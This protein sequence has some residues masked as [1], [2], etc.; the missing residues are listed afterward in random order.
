MKVFYDNFQG[1]S[2]EERLCLKTC[3]ILLYDDNKETTEIPLRVL[4]ELC[5]DL[6][7]DG[8]VI[9]LVQKNLLKFYYYRVGQSPFSD[10]LR[11]GLSHIS[12]P[13]SLFNNLVWKLIARTTTSCTSDLSFVRHYFRLSF[14][15]IKFIEAHHIKIDYDAFALLLIN[16]SRGNDFF[17]LP[18]HVD[19]PDSLTVVKALKTCKQNI[20]EKDTLLYVS[21]LSNLARFYIN[22]FD[23]HIALPFLNEAYSIMKSH[24]LQDSVELGELY[25]IYA[26]YW[27]NY[28]SFAEALRFC[29][30][31]YVSTDKEIRTE[32][33][34]YICWILAGIGDYNSC[35]VWL[36]RIEIIG[37]PKTNKLRIVTSL[38]NALLCENNHDKA[39][40][41]VDY[42]SSSLMTIN[43]NAAF[44]SI[45]YY[46][47]SII[48]QR[49][50]LTR[51]SN[52]WYLSYAHHINIHYA[53]N[54][55]ALLIYNAAEC[56]RFLDYDAMV[57]AK[58]IMFEYLDLFDISDLY[59]FSVKFDMTLVYIRF[60]RALGFPQL[61]DIYIE[62]LNELIKNHAPTEECLA[63]ITPIF[64]DHIVPD[65]LYNENFWVMENEKLLNHFVTKKKMQMS[66]IQD[67]YSNF[68][69]HK[70]YIHVM[71]A[72]LM[73][74]NPI[75]EYENCI[76]N[77][78]YNTKYEITMLCARYASIQGFISEAAKYYI[79]ALNSN[80][81]EKDNYTR[82]AD[83]I[84]IA[85]ALEKAGVYDKELEA[86]EKAEKIAKRLGS[87]ALV[88]IYQARANLLF[89]N[90][91]I[92]DAL[93][94]IEEALSVYNP[95]DG[96]IDERLCSMLC[97]KSNCLLYMKDY[98]EA[99]NAA[100]ESIKYIPNDNYESFS[101]LFN[102]AF[103]STCTKRYF[104]ARKLLVKINKLARSEE[105][106]NDVNKLLEIIGLPSVLREEYVNSLLEG[107]SVNN[108]FHF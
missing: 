21:V 101:S 69:Q 13:L 17:A 48:M 31:A 62:A 10:E 85:T 27:Y 65:C 1:L 18:E 77:A 26:R 23:Y 24:G 57:S 2:L 4:C 81:K 46:V 83:L 100:C 91:V 49:C 37:L 15:V 14:N 7:Y 87:Y 70:D 52:Q 86:W 12:Y 106:K 67:L 80:Q 30:M 33:M 39:E 102:V 3:S 60:H 99:Y 90:G 22:A 107:N 29:Y 64:V 96:L 32:A 104:E 25:L 97:L 73:D 68:P 71:S 5:D 89:T 36:N 34:L 44:F 98:E 54:E 94:Y 41:F 105:G 19:S 72:S 28:G 88:D 95:E 42:A 76:S 103:L 58:N 11:D 8:A 45:I 63:Y 56:Q 16:Y 40:S 75:E 92:D 108:N 74:S 93:S 53:S 47:K 55:A 35:K 59:S 9:S 43:K 78:S 38:I 82:V 20:T 61:S 84:E 50:G 66:T 79:M 6:T 51:D